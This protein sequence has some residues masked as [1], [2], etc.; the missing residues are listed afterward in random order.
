MIKFLNIK[1]IQYIVTNIPI[2][3]NPVT[4]K[5]HIFIKN[6]EIELTLVGSNSV[7]IKFIVLLTILEFKKINDIPQIKPST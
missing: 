5:E 2:N 4:V 7:K 6:K 3:D 1:T